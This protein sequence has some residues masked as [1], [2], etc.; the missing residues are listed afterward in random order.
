VAVSPWFEEQFDA[1]K[2]TMHLDSIVRSLHY[3]PLRG[4]NPIPSAVGSGSER[5]F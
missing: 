3:Q 5:Y 4:S 2:Q 1:E